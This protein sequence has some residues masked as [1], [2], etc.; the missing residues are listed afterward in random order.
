MKKMLVTL[1]MKKI[2]DRL[3]I[4]EKKEVCHFIINEKMLATLLLMKKI[5]DHLIINEKK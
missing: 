2:A 4:N 1:L 3:I 5:V